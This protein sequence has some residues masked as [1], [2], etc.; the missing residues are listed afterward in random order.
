ME[1]GTVIA[2]EENGIEV[3]TGDGTLFVTELQVPGKRR[4]T[5]QDFLRG[6]SFL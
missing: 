4:M 5:A 1:P 2:E 3:A 6:N